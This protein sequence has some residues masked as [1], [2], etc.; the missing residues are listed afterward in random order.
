MALLRHNGAAYCARPFPKDVGDALP[1]TQRIGALASEAAPSIPSQRSGPNNECV[2][3]RL[4]TLGVAERKSLKQTGSRAKG[5]PGQTEIDGTTKSPP[6][7][8][9]VARRR[10]STSHSSDLSSSHSDVLTLSRAR[11]P[12]SSRLTCPGSVRLMQPTL[13]ATDPIPAPLRRTLVAMLLPHAHCAF[14]DFSRMQPLRLAWTGQWLGS[15]LVW[16]QKRFAGDRIRGGAPASVLW[17]A[18][19]SDPSC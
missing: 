19:G 10:S 6:C 3:F 2:D 16:R 18:I 14:A 11:P 4:S 17:R 9:V 1:E 5:H 15:P 12:H 7:N 8:G 13:G